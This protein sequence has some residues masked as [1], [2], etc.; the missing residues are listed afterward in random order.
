MTRDEIIETMARAICLYQFGDIETHGSARCCQ[1]GGVHG[2]CIGEVK[3]V[4]SCALSALEAKGMVLAPEKPTEAMVSG[5]LDVIVGED[6][7]GNIYCGV[8]E[9]KEV[10]RAMLS[11]FLN[12]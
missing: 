4:A 7:G 9:A 11:A 8:H 12:P 10:Y 5:A 2:C 1:V 3:G 6:H